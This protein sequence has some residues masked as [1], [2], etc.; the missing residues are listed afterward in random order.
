MT[1][2]VWKSAVVA[3]TLST[4]ATLTAGL[5]VGRAWVMTEPID[6]ATLSSMPYDEAIAYTHARSRTVSGLAYIKHIFEEP[7]LLVVNL[8]GIAFLFVSHL[9]AC[10]WIMAWQQRRAGPREAG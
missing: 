3:L 4:L 2:L 9:I 5:L 10:V 6:P 7:T 8:Q 1:R